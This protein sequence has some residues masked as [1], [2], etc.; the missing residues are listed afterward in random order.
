MVRRNFTR[1]FKL[2]RK[3]EKEINNFIIGEEGKE[4]KQDFNS[5]VERIIKIINKI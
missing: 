2:L 5:A 3:K 4:N 1:E